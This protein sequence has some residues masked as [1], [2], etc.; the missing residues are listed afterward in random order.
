[1][2]ETLQRMKKDEIR[3]NHLG[4]DISHLVDFVIAHVGDAD[5]R[6]TPEQLELLYTITKDVDGFAQKY[7][8][9]MWLGRYLHRRSDLKTKSAAEFQ[10][11]ELCTASSGAYYRTFG[12]L[13]CHKNL[14][15]AFT[16]NI[17]ISISL[18]LTQLDYTKLS[19]RQYHPHDT[20]FS[21]H[22]Q[23][24]S[25]PSLLTHSETPRLCSCD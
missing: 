3:L 10:L 15:S 2:N 16:K 12:W 11:N 25:I 23:L 20:P 17:T 19:T 5:Q 4:S 22:V 21:P 6:Y 1:M 9:R 7:G 13:S 18:T 24:C 14:I 8:S